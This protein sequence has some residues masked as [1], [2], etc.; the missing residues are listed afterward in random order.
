MQIKNGW[1]VFLLS[2]TALSA[3]GQGTL[4]VLRQSAQKGDAA[5]QLQ[6]GDLYRTGQALPHDFGEAVRRYRLSAEQGNIAAKL[7]LGTMYHLGLWLGKDDA[8]E[9]NWSQATD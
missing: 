2:L 5:A 1:L 3:I 9:A 7:N 4:E 6:L 8:H